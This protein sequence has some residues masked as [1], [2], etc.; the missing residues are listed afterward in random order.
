MIAKLV[1]REETRAAAAHTLIA[2]LE[3]TELLGLH[4]NAR[5]L[6]ACLT[7]PDFA[8]GVESTAFVEENAADLHTEHKE[9]EARAAMLAAALAYAAE[10]TGLVH[11]FPM[12]L[13]FA[14]GNTVFEPVV[15]ADQRGRTEVVMDARKITLRVTRR[16]HHD[17]WYQQENVTKRAVLVQKSGNLW[18]HHDGQT[19]QFEDRSLSAATSASASQ[20]TVLRAMM[21]G[22]VT[23]LHVEVGDEVE[24]GQP[25]AVLHAM[26]MEHVHHAGASGVVRDIRAQDG[27]QVAAGD[28][29][30]EIDPGLSPD[31][32]R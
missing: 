13:R 20:N 27:A 32:D 21:A 6:R 1:A 31:P 29:L 28:I 22:T 7:H 12:P 30:L 8:A 15:R 19:W 4:T 3:Q 11:K 23:V 25:L 16:D 2:A 24:H 18:L 10:D 26:K 5:F 9:D 14:N 17:V